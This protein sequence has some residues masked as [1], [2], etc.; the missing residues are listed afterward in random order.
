MGG[1]V[2]ANRELG[3]G[4]VHTRRLAKMRVRMYASRLCILRLA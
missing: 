2:L 1:S 3:T 4:T